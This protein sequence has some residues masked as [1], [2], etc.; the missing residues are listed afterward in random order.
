MSG[1]S[2]GSGGPGE[3]GKAVHVNKAREQEMKELF[4]L[5]QFN[6]MASD[7]ISLNRSL[8]DYRSYAYAYITNI[9]TS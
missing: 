1:L 8:P 4:K 3:M 2:F 9:P 6:V 7:M 5:N